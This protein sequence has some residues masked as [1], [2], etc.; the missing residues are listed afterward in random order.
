MNLMKTSFS[1]EYFWGEVWSAALWVEQLTISH[2]NTVT[3]MVILVSLSSK[4]SVSVS[5]FEKYL[6][7]HI[8]IWQVTSQNFKGAMGNLDSFVYLYG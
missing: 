7:A 3:I 5:S 1:V 4:F 6:P 8:G 2:N